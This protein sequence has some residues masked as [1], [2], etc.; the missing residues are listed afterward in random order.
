[1]AALSKWLERR[2]ALLLILVGVLNVLDAVLTAGWMS[3]G[4]IEEANPLMAYLLDLGPTLFFIV[5]A[6]LVPLGC[7]ILWR[8]RHRRFAKIAI[9]GVLGVYSWVIVLH[10]RVWILVERLGL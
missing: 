5:K 2:A 1:V 4:V 8:Y 6:A 9:V 7:F 3:L 10:F